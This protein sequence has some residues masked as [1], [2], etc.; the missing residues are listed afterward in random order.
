MKF[1]YVWSLC[2]IVTTLLTVVGSQSCFAQTTPD[3]SIELKRQQERQEQ[4]KKRLL[5]NPDVKSEL[6]SSSNKDLLPKDEVKC[7]TIKNIFLDDQNSLPVPE[8]KWLEQSLSGLD[9]KDSPIGKCIGA[10]GLNLLLKRGQDAL[11]EKGFTTTRFVTREQN[12]QSGNLT[13]TVVEGRVRNI[14]LKKIGEKASNSNSD[15]AHVIPLKKGDILNLR[16]IEQALESFKKV[17]T[18]EADIKIEPTEM[19]G[20]SDIVIEWKQA[21]KLRYSTSID[22]A[23]SPTTG[24]YQLSGTV[25]V[26]NP[27]DLSDIFYLSAN[28]GLGGKEGPTPKGTQ[29]LTMYYSVPYGYWNFSS[30]VSASQYLQ[31]VIGAFENYEYTGNSQNFDLTASNVIY[32]DAKNKASLFGKLQ[33]KRSSNFI[34]GTEVEVQRRA[35]THLDIGY[36]HRLYWNDITIDGKLTFK[37]GLKAFGALPA[38]EELFDEGTSQYRIL[39]AEAS[40]EWPLKW[41]ER[42][43]KLDSNFKLQKNLTKLTSQEKFS[44]G[45]R[46][47]VRGIDSEAS[48]SAEQGFYVQNTLTVPIAKGYPDLYI[49]LDAGVV[50]GESAIN[51]PGKNLVGM[52]LGF[53][54]ELKGINYEF[55]AGKA[56]LKPADLKTKAV[57][58]INF[59]YAF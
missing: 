11:I 55:F 45:G 21:K 13:L 36:Q 57:Y 35:T 53:K 31:T 19:M 24:Q 49:G 2:L 18:I 42:Q 34:D 25:S 51:L 10:K 28:V 58:G 12:I 20:Q 14:T 54:G 52:V 32:R 41:G 59:S 6:K 5:E 1:K 16:A 27:F 46:Y 9:E 7:W 23:G 29:G 37:Q 48:L 3:P 22:D 26:D 8:F 30:T 44:I 33:I 56:L 40:L 4:E 38:A 39:S 50:S 17:P 43:L 15:Y 47:S